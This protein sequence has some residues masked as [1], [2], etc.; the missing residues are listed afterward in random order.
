MN[1]I[2][3]TITVE[4][5][6]MTQG[7]QTVPLA[8][9]TIDGTRPPFALPTWWPWAVAVIAIGGLWYLTREERSRPKGGAG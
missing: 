3:R 2:E 4:P 7:G 6:W 1:G 9:I 5:G 8:P